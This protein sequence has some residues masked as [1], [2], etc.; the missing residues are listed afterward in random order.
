VTDKIKV[1]I[2]DLPFVSAAVQKH[3]DYIA[4]QTLALE[5]TLAPSDL[6]AA[7]GTR[8]IDIEEQ[9]V[10]VLVEKI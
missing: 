2:E 8:E 9:M 6:L 5:I 1:V 4:S 10:K 7:P 3:S